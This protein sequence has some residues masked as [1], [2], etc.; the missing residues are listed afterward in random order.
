VADLVKSTTRSD[1]TVESVPYDSEPIPSRIPCLSKARQ[2][3]G[4]SAVHP[5][6]DSI[7][8]MAALADDGGTA[9]DIV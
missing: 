6:E 7:G 4:Y 1:S 2:L 8:E 9:P 5:V 3:I